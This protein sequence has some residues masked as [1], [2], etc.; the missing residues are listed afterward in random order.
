MFSGVRRRWGSTK[1]WK[2]SVISPF[3]STTAPISVMA[4]WA[5]SRPWGLDVEA[6]DLVGEGLILRAV[7]GDAVV[8]VVDK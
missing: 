4:S 2:R 7:D 3:F 8:Q 1:V 5:T 6:D